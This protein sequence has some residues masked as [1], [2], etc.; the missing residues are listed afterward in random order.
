MRYEQTRHASPDSITLNMFRR[1]ILCIS[2]LISIILTPPLFIE[3]SVPSQE[4]E[5]SCICVLAVSILI[6]DFVI[7]PTVWYFIF[8]L[9]PIGQIA[10][11]WV[12]RW[13][14]AAVQVHTTISCMF[15]REQLRSALPRAGPV[16]W[17]AMRFNGNGDTIQCGF[18]YSSSFCNLISLDRK[19]L[20]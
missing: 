18:L 17:Y 19:T 11:N 12:P 9:K 1:Y 14:S 15:Y 20:F 7:F 6:F 2:A 13:S 8:G 3:V 4:S 5:R 16:Y 10:P